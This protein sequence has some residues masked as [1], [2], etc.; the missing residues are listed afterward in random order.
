MTFK[1]FIR[2]KYLILLVFFLASCSTNKD[3]L[4]FQDA[5]EYQQ[6]QVVYNDNTLQPN[7]I[8]QVNISAA[9]PETAIPYNRIQGT[10]INMNNTE[11]MNL[12]GYLVSNSGTI[13]LPI[14]GKIDV[15]GKSTNQLEKELVEL[16][17]SGDHLV[18]PSVNVRLVNGKVTVLGEVRN[19]GTFTFLEQ[20]LTISQALGLAGDL[21]ING[22]RDN[23]LL[24]REENGLRKITNIDITS[25]SWMVHPEFSKIKPN[26]VLV[27]QPNKAKVKTAGYVGNVSTMLSVATTVLSVVILLTR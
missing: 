20:N 6:T 4:Y 14:L 21:T 17:E 25:A 9:I 16:L 10:N 23:I 18:N 7:D 22:K 27:V 11:A 13:N 12:R 5:A 26:D 24:I 15:M 2:A 3:I 8:I 1:I 19:P